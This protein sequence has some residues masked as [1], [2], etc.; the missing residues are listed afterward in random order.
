MNNFSEKLTRLKFAL[1]VSKD[2]DVAEALDMK[3]PAFSERKKKDSFPD[4][5]VF[6]LAARRPE[7]ELEPQ[8]IITGIAS[9]VQIHDTIEAGLIECL[10]KMNEADKARLYNIALLWSGVMRLALPD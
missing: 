10:R 1:R 9:K 7:L 6:A 3:R 4:K 5:E 2:S 8:W